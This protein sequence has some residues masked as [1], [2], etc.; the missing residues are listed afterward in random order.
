M[1]VMNGRHAKPV[2][3]FSRPK[4]AGAVV[5]IVLG[6]WWGFGRLVNAAPAAAA[7]TSPQQ[8]HAGAAVPG[9]DLTFAQLQRGWCRTLLDSARNATERADGRACLAKADRVIA[10][11]MGHTPTPTPTSSPTASSTPTPVPTTPA[12]TLAPSTAPPTT[13]GPSPT[14]SPSPTAAG[15][16]G[17]ANEACTGTPAGW[18]PAHTINGTWNITA[19]GTYADTRVFGDIQVMADGVTLNRVEVIGGLINNRDI[20]CHNGLLLA[21]VS[22]IQSV[23]YTN[24]GS[25]GVVGPG[26]YTARQLKI[27]DRTEGARVGGKSDGGCGPVVIEDSFMRIT[28]PRPCPLDDDGNSAWHGDGIQGYDGA[29][30]RLRNTTIDMVEDG[31]G[32]TAPFYWWSGAGNGPVDVDGLVVR[33]GGFPFRLDVVDGSAVRNLMVVDGSWF[34]GPFDVPRCDQLDVWDARVVRVGTDWQ[35]TTV[36]P[37]PC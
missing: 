24:A 16:P 1:G 12:P 23:P 18:T 15:C 9:D 3:R 4:V 31:C 19:P 2:P 27:L 8:V 5:L 29:G 26:G 28:P 7:A 34:W 30:L 33:G 20:R 6:S 14:P 17:Q 21:Q 11:L 37:L 10:W 36:R 25:V 35:P 13:L 22:I 32:G